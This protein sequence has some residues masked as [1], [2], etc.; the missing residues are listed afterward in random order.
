MLFFLVQKYD[1]LINIS[2]FKVDT[3]ASF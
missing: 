2:N 3:L 1:L